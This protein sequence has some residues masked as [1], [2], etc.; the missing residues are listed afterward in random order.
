MTT[1]I[2]GLL[3]ALIPLTAAVAIYGEYQ[4][5]RRLVYIF[6]PLTTVL[7]ILL[8]I[9]GDGESVQPAYRLLIIAGLILCLGGDVF[10]ML[11]ERF[12]LPGLGSFL[13]GHWFYIAAFSA[14]VGFLFSWSLVPLILLRRRHLRPAA[15]PFGQNAAA[16]DRL[17]DHDFADGVA[18]DRPLGAARLLYRRCWRRQGRCCLSFPTPCWR[19]TV[20]GRNSGARG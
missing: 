10:L 5:T 1:F 3:S 4:T 11:P 8:A 12:F 16:G 13:A 9:V 20:F 14:S 7:I 18:S 19:W 17:C 6:K 2:V 15:S